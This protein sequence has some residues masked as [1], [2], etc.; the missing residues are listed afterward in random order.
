MDL[1]KV[2][3][4]MLEICKLKRESQT[5]LDGKQTPN[6]LTSRLLQTSSPS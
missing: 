6:A 3:S 1:K 5:M 4:I 2:Y